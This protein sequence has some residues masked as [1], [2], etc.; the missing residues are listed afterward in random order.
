VGPPRAPRVLFR[1]GDGTFDVPEPEDAAESSFDPLDPADGDDGDEDEPVEPAEPEVSANAIPG[2][3]AIAAP[4]PNA[5]A[6]AP[7]RPT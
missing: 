3:E 7:T 6:S 4:T 2:I 5:T 1:D